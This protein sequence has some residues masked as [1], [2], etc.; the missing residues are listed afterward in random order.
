MLLA[1]WLHTSA[2]LRAFNWSMALIILAGVA[3]VVFGP[4]P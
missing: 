4:A 2:R 3:V 1:R